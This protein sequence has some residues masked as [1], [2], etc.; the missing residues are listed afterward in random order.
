[1]SKAKHTFFCPDLNFGV[2]NEE[3][4]I[5][6]IRVLRLGEG[7]FIRLL[8]GKGQMILA[9]ITIADKR[10][11]GFE[12]LENIHTET[13]S[14]PLHIAI[15]PTKNIDR[16]TFFLEKAT[17][18]GIAEVTPIFTKNSERKN[19]KIDKLK[20]GMIAALK[21]SQNLF[22]PEL[23]PL[24]EFEDFIKNDHS[25]SYQF[26]A[27][28]DPALDKQPLKKCIHPKNKNIILIGPEGDFTPEELILAKEN[29]FKSVSLG[30]ARL[31]TETAGILA[32]HTVYLQS[33]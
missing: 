7:D 32:C 15:A 1:M 9:K 29:G 28:C 6:A 33:Y 23:H 18:M 27:H 5:H 10:G 17:E 31:R 26:I 21:Q 16:F 14:L 25:T 8:N 4:S 20:K 13:N 11:V 3:E 19:L 2:L 12:F 22:F 30:N 24:I